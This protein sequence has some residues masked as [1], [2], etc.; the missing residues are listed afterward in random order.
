MRF[1]IQIL[2]NLDLGEHVQLLVKRKM[3][4][5]RQNYYFQITYLKNCH[6][7][8]ILLQKIHYRIYRFFFTNCPLSSLGILP[9]LSR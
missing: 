4:F 8:E 7:E 9:S 2:K 3:V 5:I 6:E 1:Q